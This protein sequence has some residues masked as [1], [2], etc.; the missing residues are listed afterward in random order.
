M[1]ERISS[2]SRYAQLVA[3]MQNN[4]NTFNKLTA[5]LS[6]GNKIINLTEE[7][8]MNAG[9]SILNGKYKIEP[10]RIDGKNISCTFCKYKDLCYKSYED[11]L[12]LPKKTFKEDE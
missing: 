11:E 7:L 2:S 5:Q 3:A 1:V 12:D 9:N 4:Q 8:I 10:K 6:S